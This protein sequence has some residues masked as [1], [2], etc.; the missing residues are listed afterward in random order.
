MRM[1]H[2]APAIRSNAAAVVRAICFNAAYFGFR[3]A[4]PPG[5]AVVLVLD[6]AVQQDAKVHGVS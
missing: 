3:G 6:R 5:H 1:H 4:D 2:A